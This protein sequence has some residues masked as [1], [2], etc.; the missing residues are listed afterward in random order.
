[1]CQARGDFDIGILYHLLYECINIRYVINHI[2]EH[3][4][5][6]VE[7]S[8]IEL[9]LTNNRCLKILNNEGI[10]L[11]EEL[12]PEHDMCVAHQNIYHGISLD[13]V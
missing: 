13:Y 9:I 10:P 7:I 12:R 6:Q 2:K 3:I 8:L 1:M 4:T 11:P 5:G